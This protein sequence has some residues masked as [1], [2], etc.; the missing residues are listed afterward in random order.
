[1]DRFQVGDIVQ[2]FK[3]EQVDQNTSEYLYKILAFASH[4]ETGE[5]LVIYQA[6]YFPFKVCAR[7]YDMFISKTDKVKY[8]NAKQEYRFELLSREKFPVC[9]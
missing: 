3:R 1:M 2:H 6:L 7:P 9:N 4:T 8:P 5:R